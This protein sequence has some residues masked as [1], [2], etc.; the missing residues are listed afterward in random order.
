MLRK[1]KNFFNTPTYGTKFFR[2]VIIVF[3]IWQIIVII[4]LYFYNYYSD[5]NLRREMLKNMATNLS[6]I[7]ES[8]YAYYL[9]TRNHIPDELKDEFFISFT[10]SVDEELR[11]SFYSTINTIIGPKPALKT[12]NEDF[13][14]YQE[15]TFSPF[16]LRY[17]IGFFKDTLFFWHLKL[18]LPLSLLTFIITTLG[19]F[20]LYNFYRSFRKPLE[21]LVTDLNAGKVPEF[22]GYQELDRVV[23]AIRDYI[24]KEKT[25]TEEKIK[26]LK[27]LEKN[28]RLSAIGTMAG[29]YAHEFNNLLQA[30]LI[31]TELAKRALEEG[32]LGKVKAYLSPIEAVSKRGQDL[33]KKILFL[34]KITPGDEASVRE[35]LLEMQDVL[36]V[37]VPR[38]I[39]LSVEVDENP[40]HVPL[41]TDTLQEI[42]I[43]YVK[44]AVDAIRMVREDGRTFKISIRTY[45]RE[46]FAILEVEDNGCGM[47][48]EVKERIFEPF[49][50]TK[51]SPEG[52]GLGLYV[53]YN[54]VK[55]A[56]GH[57]EVES[58]PGLGSKFI[59]YIPLVNKEER[60]PERADEIDSENSTERALKRILIVDDE[61][62]IAEALKEVFSL[63]EIDSVYTTDGRSAYELLMKE[64]FDLIL[65]DVN[66][67]GMNGIDLITKLHNN[68]SIDTPIVVMTGFVGDAQAPLFEFIERG[69]VKKILKKPFTIEE[70]ENIIKEHT[71]IDN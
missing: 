61:K 11:N 45:Q 5:L 27:E 13:I 14:I 42:V 8:K 7:L 69:L 2:S 67:P 41:S 28:L 24:E 66:M 53:I 48:A 55:Q 10:K 9:E 19:I 46:N 51:K 4:T 47:S 31:N 16:N 17:Y 43:N 52:T 1:I 22:T 12:S 57:I 39:E 26:L 65:I 60:T 18:I 62:E 30:I 3:S 44:N 23:Q 33:A 59:T 35:T 37:M 32:D 20:I 38:E 70:I 50:T 56:G 29:G 34:T 25:A 71:R 21:N 40:L 54:I 58:T 68:N 15:I 63:Y 49:Y 64:K 6:L 36:R